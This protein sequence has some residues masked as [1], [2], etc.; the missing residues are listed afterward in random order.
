MQTQLITHNKVYAH[1]SLEVG[2]LSLE[3]DNL[4]ES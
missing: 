3:L 4:D 2:E 1:T